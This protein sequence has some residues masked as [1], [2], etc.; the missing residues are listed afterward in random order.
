MVAPITPQ[1]VQSPQSVTRKRRLAEAMMQQGTD[2]SPVGHPLGALARALQGGMAGYMSH[3]AD[4]AE[5]EGLAGVMAKMQS[6]DN[7]GAMMDPW[8]TD[9]MSRLAQI[10]YE[11]DNPAPQEPKVVP[12]G[13]SLY[14]DGQWITP[15]AGQG[16]GAVDFGDVAGIRKEIQD[17][18]SYKSFSQAAPVYQSMVEAAQNDSKP[19]DV[20]MVYALAKLFDPNSVV[21]EG[22]MIMVQNAQSIPDRLMALIAETN[23]GGRLNPQLRAEMLQEAQSR[24]NAYKGAFDENLKQFQGIAQRH[25]FNEADIMPTMPQMPAAPPM[26]PQAPAQQQPS[27]PPNGSPQPGMVEDGFRFK[28]GNPADPNNWEPIQ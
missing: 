5:K 20:N 13:S 12:R 25:Q 27:M 17:L 6:G 16:A 19:A 3:K 1:N 10:Q 23:K 22:E 2:T 18:P 14:Q 26:P 4:T 11:R 21:R 28:G 7:A 8:A 9:G 24:I 15:P